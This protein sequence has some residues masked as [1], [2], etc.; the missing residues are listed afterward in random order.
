MTAPVAL[1]FISMAHS[2]EITL[3]G[4]ESITPY[5][6]MWLT[7]LHSQIILPFKLKNRRSSNF[8]QKLT[9]IGVYC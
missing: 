9:R 4:K 2:G 1:S 3:P 6:Y 7:M 5:V 8:K